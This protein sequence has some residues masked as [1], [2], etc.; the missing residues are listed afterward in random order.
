M[1]ACWTL[2]QSLY[3]M[4][5]QDMWFVTWVGPLLES[6]VGLMPLFIFQA[7]RICL[8]QSSPCPP[9]SRR[10]LLEHHHFALRPFST[11]STLALCFPRWSYVA[12]VHEANSYPSVPRGGPVSFMFRKRSPA[13]C[14]YP[15]LA[16]TFTLKGSNPLPWGAFFICALPE[17]IFLKLLV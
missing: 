15:P 2:Y 3:V 17:L 7:F 16:F 6:E 12:Y 14:S 8:A 11:P 13:R 10:N 9:P 1:T 4:T 5:W